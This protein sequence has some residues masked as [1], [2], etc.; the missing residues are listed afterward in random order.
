M[1]SSI[2]FD[3]AVELHA[4]P[5]YS[6]REMMKSLS[7]KTNDD[8]INP[9]Y[10]HNG[11]ARNPIIQIRELIKSLSFNKTTARCASQTKAVLLKDCSLALANKSSLLEVELAARVLL[12]FGTSSLR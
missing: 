1:I 6:Q 9:H 3:C 2:L 11:I 7:F 10:L 12:R 8:F 5:L 4:I